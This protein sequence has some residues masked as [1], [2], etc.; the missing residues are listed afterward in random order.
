MLEKE[1][2]HLSY[3]ASARAEEIVQLEEEKR[4]LYGRLEEQCKERDKATY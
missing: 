1:V 3:Q 4:V 2:K